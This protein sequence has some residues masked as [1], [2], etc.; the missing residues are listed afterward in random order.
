MMLANTMR[1][2]N[3]ASAGRRPNTPPMSP[4]SS[5]LQQPA[6][7]LTGRGVLEHD[8]R[9]HIGHPARKASLRR[10]AEEDDAHEGPFVLRTE[11]HERIEV[12]LAVLDKLSHS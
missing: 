12:V 11:L 2:T 6:P 1:S 7:V 5:S 4:A 9:V 8:N 10:A 3:S